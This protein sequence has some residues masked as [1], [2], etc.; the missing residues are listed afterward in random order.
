MTGLS[1]LLTGL[2]VA[3]V[4]W[5]AST[6]LVLWLVRRP[7]GATGAILGVG[8]VLAVAALAAL[9]WA[10]REPGVVGSVVG[11]VAALTVW[12][13]HELAFL[14]GRV[15][16]DHSRLAPPAAGFARFRAAAAAVMHHELALA[17]TLAVVVALAW[18]GANPTGLITFAVLFVLRLSTKLNIYLGVANPPLA[19]LP[20][21]LEHL[22]V[23]FVRRPLNALMP[24][25]LLA[26]TG[27]TWAL[28]SRA[29][30]PELGSGAALGFALTAGL[31]GL[32]LIEH[33]FLM[34]PSPDRAL[35]GW[36]LERDARRPRA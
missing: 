35:W 12:G 29:V 2:G 9:A 16:G 33:L 4:L 13:W 6:G 19:F 8:G 7:V 28:A 21:A 24:L 32:G 34:A 25:S 18:N 30:D 5:W 23:W 27:L 36:A 17:A 11:F 20:A 10:A 3:L 26:S 1:P 14:S 22:R 15:S 31:A